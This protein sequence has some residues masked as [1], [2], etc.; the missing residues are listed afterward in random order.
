MTQSDKWHFAVIGV[1]LLGVGILV[2]QNVVVVKPKQ[3]CVIDL[4][5]NTELS[6]DAIRDYCRR[7]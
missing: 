6:D 4:I 3:D 7:M 1:I 2:Y 5:K